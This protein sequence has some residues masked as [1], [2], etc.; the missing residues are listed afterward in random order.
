MTE[1]ILHNFGGRQTQPW[2]STA[3]ATCYSSDVGKGLIES[4]IAPSTTILPRADGFP[5][6]PLMVL[7]HPRSTNQSIKVQSIIG[8]G[9]SGPGGDSEIPLATLGGTVGR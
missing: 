4:P 3:R 6:T 7:C 1:V 2:S 8:K 9:Q 5:T